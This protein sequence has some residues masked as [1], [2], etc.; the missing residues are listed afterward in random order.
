MI[1]NQNI[2]FIRLIASFAY[3][4]YG[5]SVEYPVASNTVQKF[6]WGGYKVGV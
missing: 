1:T 2:I 3:D 5:S 6:Y 4:K